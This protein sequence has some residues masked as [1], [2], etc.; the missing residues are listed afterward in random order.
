MHRLFG[1]ET[2]R[3]AGIGRQ[4]WLRAM[5]PLGRVGSTPILGTKKLSLTDG[6][7]YTLRPND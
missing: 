5:C 4:A 2:H 1:L 3:G 6:F 7:F